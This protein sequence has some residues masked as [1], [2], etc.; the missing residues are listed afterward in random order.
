M[1]NAKH[2]SRFF[3]YTR[4]RPP[5]KAMRIKKKRDPAGSFEE[6]NNRHVDNRRFGQLTSSDVL[7]T[8]IPI[9]IK[10][11][12]EFL[13]SS[14][15]ETRSLYFLP[16]KSEYH[17]SMTSSNEIGNFCNY[18]LGNYKIKLVRSNYLCRS[19]KS[20]ILLLSIFRP[21]KDSL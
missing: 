13:F 15:Y 4:R 9:E 20:R 2:V 10:K 8:R 14:V 19:R 12:Y 6:A 7:L 16:I 11:H 3:T 21:A 1:H 17:S 18:Y 5:C